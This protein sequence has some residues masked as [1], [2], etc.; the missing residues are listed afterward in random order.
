MFYSLSSSTMRIAW[1][2]GWSSLVV[3]DPPSLVLNARMPNVP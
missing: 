2:S 1:V 3:K